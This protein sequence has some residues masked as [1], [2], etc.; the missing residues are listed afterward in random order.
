M[1]Y[2]MTITNGNLISLNLK[3]SNGQ[4]SIRQL[5]AEESNFHGGNSSKY[6][7]YDFNLR[8]NNLYISFIIRLELSIDTL[9]TKYVKSQNV[10]SLDGFARHD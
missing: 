7:T 8:T 5:L 10:C 2:Q 3:L 4:Q 1:K 9:K 6:L